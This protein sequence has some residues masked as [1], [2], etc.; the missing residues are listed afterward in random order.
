MEE[1]S[2]HNSNYW[3][4]LEKSHESDISSLDK[5]KLAD[6]NLSAHKESNNMLDTSMERERQERFHF[7]IEDVDQ[8]KR[9]P[10]FMISPN[11]FFKLFW[12]MIILVL[13]VYT[14]M[15]WPIRLAFM[16][17]SNQSDGLLAFDLITDAL[18]II[19]II[20]NFFFVEED[21][22][23]EMIIDI[24][25]L[26]VAY[27]KTWFFVD[28]VASVP[29]SLI[30]YIM[31]GNDTSESGGLASIRFLKLTKFT[32]LY[33]LLTLFKMLKLFKN[34]RHLE[35][36]VSYLNVSSDMKQIISSLVR[37]VFLL[38]IVGCSFA[39]VALMSGQ[40]YMISWI[41]ALGI[42]DESV[43]TRYVAACYWAVVTIS[44]VGYGDITPTN[45][46]EVLTT[47]ILVF[48]GVSMYSYI[49]S[50]LTSIFA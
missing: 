5:E 14:A 48:I 18:F 25:K 39:I 28:V 50:R 43:T 17:E 47:I 22:N 38:H 31:Y 35:I 21:V 24:K 11:S 37:M 26:A 49:I 2:A 7:D 41:S 20:L 46:T 6:K 4:N 44:T 10:R 13:T 3:S 16:E 45:E 30:F 42:D 19:D 34:H 8:E 9:I 27:L 33:R 15:F 1:G 23:G 40:G 36:A 29:I 12:N 32:R